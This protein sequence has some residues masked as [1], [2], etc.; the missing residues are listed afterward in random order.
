M[1]AKDWLR[2]WLRS[3]RT[4]QQGTQ[5]LLTFLDKELG[6]KPVNPEIYLQAFRHKTSVKKAS[7]S[8]E[9][10][11]FVGDAILD[12]VVASYLYHRYPTRDEGFLSKMKSAVV[13]RQTLNR[14]A[15]D[16]KLEP[17]IQAR[18]KNRNA[19][20]VIGGNVLEALIGAVYEDLGFEETQ[21]WVEKY[22]LRNLEESK[23]FEALKDAKSELFEL[24]QQQNI[25]LRFETSEQMDD[26]GSAFVSAVHW[27]GE[28]IAK[29]G[30]R[31]KKTAEQNAARKA[32]SRINA[33]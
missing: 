2:R 14:L 8:N 26:S 5:D 17:L 24:S 18:V 28:I 27:K 9:R 22:I 20:H 30:G 13:N 4:G 1:T 23:L 29:A 11:E 12:A 10:L 6:L 31:S 15:R 25:D 21:R 3:K 32:L 7:E 19:M 16:L 33:G